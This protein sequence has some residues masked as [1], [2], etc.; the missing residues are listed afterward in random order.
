MDN[1]N[2]TQFEDLLGILIGVSLNS[3]E[4]EI[5]TILQLERDLAD[6]L[7]LYKIDLKYENRII[8]SLPII[9]SKSLAIEM[10]LNNVNLSAEVVD[11]DGNDVILIIENNL[12]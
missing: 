12:I 7:N 1:V 10:D 8:G 11:I 3:E 2:H 9:Y 4:L 5:G 6:K